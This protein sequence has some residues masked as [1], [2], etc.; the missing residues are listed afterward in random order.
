MAVLPDLLGT[1][2][3]YTISL[4]LLR[5]L[6]VQRRRG[7]NR[8]KIIFITA[9]T[10]A[11]IEACRTKLLKLMDAY[12]SIDSYP[13]AWLRDIKVEVVTKGSGHSPPLKEGSSQIG[14]ASC[15]ER[16]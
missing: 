8:T 15:R 12:R 5:L 7:D 14:R 3:T 13:T 6:E 11:A 4:S 2:K 9:I 16:V 1:G 10:H